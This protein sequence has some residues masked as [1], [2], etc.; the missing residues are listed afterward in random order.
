M[1]LVNF[2][3]QNLLRSINALSGRNEYGNLE[4]MQVAMDFVARK[5]YDEAI[6]YIRNKNIN[7]NI[8]F[9]NNAT[10]VESSIM[11]WA[12]SK[13]NWRFV[14]MLVE[15]G[16]DI[17]TTSNNLSLMSHIIQ[18]NKLA[19]PELKYRY[20]KQLIELGANVNFGID[21]ETQTHVPIYHAVGYPE[22]MTLL[23]ENGAR[24]RQEEYLNAQHPFGHALYTEALSKHKD[25][26]EHIDIN[27]IHKM[28]NDTEFTTYGMID[29]Y[30]RRNREN[31]Q[32][33]V[34]YEDDFI[35]KFIA[36]NPR[37]SPGERHRYKWDDEI[38]RFKT[39]D[40]FKALISPRY[41]ERIGTRSQARH[42]PQELWREVY[43]AL[44]GEKKFKPLMMEAY[45]N[46]RNRIRRLRG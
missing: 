5:K 40:T 19:R 24:I 36:Q 34:R 8:L 28:G 21:H 32:P 15:T 18:S 7:P 4:E 38:D 17:N 43:K 6:E 11:R 20:V 26:L 35:G 27:F 14:M 42:L 46:E 30:D 16:G 45:E 1:D 39:W 22:I 33:I 29:V 12:M 44:K 41:V 9:R 23:L 25:M 10:N 31:Q 13:E 37:K 2:A 3:W